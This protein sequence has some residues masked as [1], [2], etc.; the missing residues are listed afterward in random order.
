MVTVM[1]MQVATP[2]HS[3]LKHP[4]SISL[5]S[6]GGKKMSK[7]RAILK[8]SGKKFELD[9]KTTEGTEKPGSCLLKIA[10]EVG[11]LRPTP[12]ASV[13]ESP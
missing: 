8:V 3:P 5:V 10:Q 4:F 13:I 9:V 12:K 2:H 7:K 6:R 1:E 11:L